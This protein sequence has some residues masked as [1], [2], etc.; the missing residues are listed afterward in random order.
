MTK[1]HG[2]LGLTLALC[3]GCD[4]SERRDAAMVLAAIGRF[5]GASLADTPAAVETLAHVRCAYPDSCS[6]RDACVTSG[7]LTSKA[8]VLKSDVE[9]AL[10]DL[11]QGRL[12]KDSPKAQAL[13]KMLDD[14]EA[15]LQRG[16][17]ELSSCDERTRAL[18]RRHHL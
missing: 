1:S 2:V 13:P 14:A 17:E 6:A 11:E 10:S 9:H 15:Q 5:R 3:L 7:R 8:I 12:S 4:V 16:K 18:R